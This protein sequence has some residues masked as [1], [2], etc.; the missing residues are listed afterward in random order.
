LHASG[1]AWAGLGAGTG[2]LE[3]RVVNLHVEGRGAARLARVG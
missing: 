2:L 1:G 3:S